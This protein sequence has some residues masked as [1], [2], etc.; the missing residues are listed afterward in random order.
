MNRVVIIV[1]ASAASLVL[2]LVLLMNYGKPSS[3]FDRSGKDGAN[4]PIMLYCAASNRAVMEAIRGDYEQEFGRVVQI[5]YGASQTLLSSLQISHTGDLFL[6]ADDSYIRIARDKGL[7]AEVLP[8]AGMKAVIAVKKGNPKHITSLA[9]LLKPD[10][11]LVQA[12]PDAAAIGKVTREVLTES[13]NWS[14]I[15]SATLAFRTTVT[16][17]A[18]DLLV[19]AADAGIVY[20]AVLYAYPDLEAVE[21]PELEPA[22]S[23]IMLAVTESTEQ[24]QAALHFARYVAARDRGLVQYEAHGFQPEEG[25]EWSDTPQ[26]NVFAGSMLRPAIDETLTAFEQREGVEITRVYNGCGILVAQ[27]KAGQRPDA[28][29]ACDSEFMNSVSELFP[30]PVDVSQNELVILVQKGNPREIASLKDLS[31]EGLRVGVGHEKQCAMGWLTQNTLKEAGVQQEVMANV[32][33]QSPTGD[34]L[35][36]QLRVGSLD[37]AVVYLS[38]AAGSADE[39]D[40]VRI[41]GLACAVATQPFAIAQDSRYHQLTAR[42]FEALR[43]A[44]SHDNFLAEGFRWQ[45]PETARRSP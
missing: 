1:G 12:S 26:L 29:F 20:D 41:Q 6:P 8:L 18:N 4:D 16:D 31:V 36:N 3:S 24:P 45:L 22:A 14:P 23:L 42:M 39:L 17:V 11:R 27:M 28:Y 43:T 40:A 7:I 2:L 35:V 13:G 44:E 15:E 9:D 33:L 21:I 25:D 32:A 37:A 19:G 38:N 10:V 5:Q 30:D 34:M